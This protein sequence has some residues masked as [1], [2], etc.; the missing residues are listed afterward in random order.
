MLKVDE[1]YIKFNLEWTPGD[2][3]PGVVI[4]DMIEWRNKM[5]AMGLMGAYANG[6][7]FGNLSIRHGNDNQFIVSGTQTGHIQKI[8]SR[9]FTLVTEVDFSQNKLS[10]KGPV[11]ASSESMTHAMLYKIDPSINAVM[12]VHDKFLWSSQKKKLPT[13]PKSAHNGTTELAECI[14]GLYHEGKLANE[15]IIIMGGH[16]GGILSFGSSLDE[17]GEVL[18]KYA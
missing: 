1:G 9:H 12:H 5:Y 3:L 11:K 10:C 8:L 16:E 2:A 7:G 13:T 14:A 18:Q 6:V 17:A 4:N 15:K